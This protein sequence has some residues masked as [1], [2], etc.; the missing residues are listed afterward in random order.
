LAAIA[1]SGSGSGA[2]HEVGTSEASEATK[3]KSKQ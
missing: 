1:S 3:Q 2:A